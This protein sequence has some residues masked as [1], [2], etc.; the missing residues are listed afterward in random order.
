M[1]HVD[2][3]WVGPSGYRLIDGT[4]LHYGET[5]VSVP[6]GE[7]VGSDNWHPVDEVDDDETE[8]VVVAPEP[9][10]D[11]ELIDPLSVESDLTDSTDTEGSD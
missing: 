6:S 4:V 1:A 7:A 9:N 8:T 3:I 2:A 11:D 5:V 10:E